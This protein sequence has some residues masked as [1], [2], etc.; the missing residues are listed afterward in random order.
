MVLFVLNG[1][2]S[3]PGH[4]QRSSN[5]RLIGPSPFRSCWRHRAAIPGEPFCSVGKTLSAKRVS[6]GPQLEI[7]QLPVSNDDPHAERRSESQGRFL[8]LSRTAI[9][10]ATLP[11]G[12]RVTAMVCQRPL[13]RLLGQLPVTSSGRSCT[14]KA[15][16]TFAREGFRAAWSRLKWEGNDLAHWR[17]RHAS[18]RATNIR[19]VITA[20]A[21]ARSTSGLGNDFRIRRVHGERRQLLRMKTP[22]SSGALN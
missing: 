21:C 4:F 13:L 8:A 15:I 1:C 20:F 19:G 10:P 7:L 5:P 9:D 11:T 16:E 17:C 2:T 3:G 14:L 12:T 22:V 18:G 6:E